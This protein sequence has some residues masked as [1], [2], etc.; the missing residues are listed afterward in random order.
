MP[1]VVVFLK[2][3]LILQL[4]E[5]EKYPGKQPQG[6]GL[7][8][9]DGQY[10][11][12]LRWIAHAAWLKAIPTTNLGHFQFGIDSGVLT[13]RVLGRAFAQVDMAGEKWRGEAHAAA[14]AAAAE[15]GA[16]A[17]VAGSDS[18]GGHLTPS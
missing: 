5:P 2:H 15:A 14:E 10:Q 9:Q 4:F 18:T 16:A 6:A 7:N 12:L 1:C 13:D 11:H 17:G 8:N 3:T